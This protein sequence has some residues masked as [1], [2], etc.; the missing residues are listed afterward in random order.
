MNELIWKAAVCS[1]N[2]LGS[3]PAEVNFSM[4]RQAVFLKDAFTAWC[5]SLDL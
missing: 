3:S 4:D 2:C 5:E 1:V